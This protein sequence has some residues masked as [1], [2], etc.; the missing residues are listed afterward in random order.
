MI[1]GVPLPGGELLEGEK[2]LEAWVILAKSSHVFPGELWVP[3]WGAKELSRLSQTQDSF[4]TW[5]VFLR[6]PKR[7]LVNLPRGTGI[8]LE[9]GHF[10]I[11][12]HAMLNWENDDQP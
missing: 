9:R 4:P 8:S 5:I 7:L 6:F 2:V 3:K 1:R 12:T 11:P 10:S